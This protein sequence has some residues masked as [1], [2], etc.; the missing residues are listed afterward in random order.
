MAPL[1][2]EI[3]REVE[4]QLVDLG[5][6][7]VAIE[8]AGGRNRPVIRI[9]M[10]RVEAAGGGVTVGDCAQVSRALEGWL[11]ELDDLAERYVLE[12]S[13]PGV[14]RPLTRVRDWERFAGQPVIVEGYDVLAERSSRLEAD[15]L[16][17][18]PEPEPAA[19]LKLGDGTEVKVPLAEI[20]GAHLVFEWK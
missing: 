17:L 12:V 14:E 7:L 4:K 8:W 1:R 9:R 6:E 11:D 13:S 5:F 19:R 18:E 15:L 10:D 2:A 3:E 16:G 20:K